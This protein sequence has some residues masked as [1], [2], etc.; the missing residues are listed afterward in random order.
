MIVKASTAALKKKASTQCAS[1][2]R[3]M[4]REVIETHMDMFAADGL[5]TLVL[6]RRHLSQGE[7]QQFAEKWSEAEKAMIGRDELMAEAARLI[8]R[9]L[10]VVGVTAIEDK[11]QDG[12]PQTIKDLGNAGEK[13]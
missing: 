13:T 11:L 5:R 9:D 6:A 7:Y 8:E 2:V 1:P 10:T 3:R 12:V 4:A